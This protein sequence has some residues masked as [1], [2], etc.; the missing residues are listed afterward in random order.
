QHATR[1]V[2]LVDGDRGGRCGRGRRRLCRWQRG[3]RRR[4]YRTVIDQ[5]R[6]DCAGSGATGDGQRGHG[7]QQATPKPFWWR[8]RRGCRRRLRLWHVVEVLISDHLTFTSDG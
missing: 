8:R 2:L 4:G 7:G 5:G 6:R 1:R 3:A